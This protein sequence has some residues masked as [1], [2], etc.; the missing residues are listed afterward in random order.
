[1]C[2]HWIGNVSVLYKTDG[3]KITDFAVECVESQDTGVSD[4]V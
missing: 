3:E 4:G 2:S 1:M